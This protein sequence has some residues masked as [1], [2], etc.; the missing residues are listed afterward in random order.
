MR[1]FCC[2]L[3]FFSSM[4]LPCYLL[5]NAFLF[6]RLYLFQIFC[7]FNNTVNILFLSFEMR[8]YNWHQN[9]ILFSRIKMLILPPVP[10]PKI[11]GIDPDLLKVINKL[12][13]LYITL[14]KWYLN[15][16]VLCWDLLQ[17][18]CI[19]F[20]FLYSFWKKSF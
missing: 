6:L 19:T 1:V 14:I 16:N 20:Y 10:V 12:S 7:Y 3:F 13:K 11:K 9:K 8:M 18:I 5:L 2:F 4:V 17:A 15:N